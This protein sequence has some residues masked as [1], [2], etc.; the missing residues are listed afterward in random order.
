VVRSEA[1]AKQQ[2]QALD[3]KVAKAVAGLAALN[4]R[5]QGKKRLT[6]AEL[7]ASSEQMVKR[8]GV[9]DLLEFE[10]ETTVSEIVQRKYKDRPA[11]VQEVQEQT[12]KARVKTDAV[13][14]KKR[15][16]GWRVY[17]TN[18]LVLTVMAA[19][20]AYRGQYGIEHGFARLKGKTLNLT[21][22][23]LQKE[24]R[25][26]GLVKL[27]SIGL[28]LLTL[29]EFEV[30][31][32]LEETGEKLRGVYPGQAGRSTSRPSSE[33]LL[34]VF[35]GVDMWIVEHEGVC[36]RKVSPLTV[37][38]KQI[39]K[40]LDLSPSIYQGLSGTFSQSG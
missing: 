14:S 25:V 1:H 3:G 36:Y 6:A 26:S 7:T 32:K 34:E 18:A 19:V 28:R 12:V 24:E 9:A 23:Y 33:L 29:I 15:L 10:V 17:V 5:K 8:Y 35:R 16:C 39:L 37:A 20:Q 11:G 21:P 40:M 31:R 38:Q 27:L 2:Q 4:E 22:L 13:E 30:R